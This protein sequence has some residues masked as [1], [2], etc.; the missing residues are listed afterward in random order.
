MKSRSIQT[1]EQFSLIL[2][3]ITFSSTDNRLQALHLPIPNHPLPLNPH[4]H[5]RQAPLR[6]NKKIRR[7]HKTKPPQ[8][9]TLH[10]PS[11]P[12]SHSRPRQRRL[13]P[14]PPGSHMPYERKPF[15]RQCP[16]LDQTQWTN[17][18]YFHCS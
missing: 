2:T 1:D 15:G 8:L 6:P 10:R 7:L 4:P 9:E 13:R 16:T 11:H 14:Q 3:L 5:S 17:K 18:P 12:H